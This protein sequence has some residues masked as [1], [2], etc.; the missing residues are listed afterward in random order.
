MFFLKKNKKGFT[1]IE[2]MMYIFIMLLIT[3]MVASFLPQLV[4]NNLNI[5]ARGE[6]LG[7]TRSALEVIAQEIR[8]ASNIYTPTSIFDSSPGQLSL[9][10]TNNVP[11]G[12]TITFIDFFV[13]GDRLYMKREGVVSEIIVS[14]KTKID[15]LTFTHINSAG[16]YQAVR[17]SITASYDSPSTEIQEKSSVTLTTTASLRSY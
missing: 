15:D 9:E 2:M 10:S 13:D 6:V 5:Q 12:E 4:R 14:Q 11:V 7:N 17:V 3:T 8:H 16:S 1:L